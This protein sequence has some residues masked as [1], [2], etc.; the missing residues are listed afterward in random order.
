MALT[1]EEQAIVDA[2]TPTIL[3][4]AAR[5]QFLKN[6]KSTNLDSFTTLVTNAANDYFTQFNLTAPKDKLQAV[7]L[8]RNALSGAIN[9]IKVI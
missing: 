5:D 3:A 8:I 6:L 9:T 4:Q 2:A 1:T 7:I